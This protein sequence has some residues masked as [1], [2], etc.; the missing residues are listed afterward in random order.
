MNRFMQ[1]GPGFFYIFF[2]DVQEFSH[3]DYI[4][5]VKHHIDGH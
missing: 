5:E 2:T 1:K 4:C 3:G